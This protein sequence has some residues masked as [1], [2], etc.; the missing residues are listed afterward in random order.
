[1]FNSLLPW[2]WKLWLAQHWGWYRYDGIW[3]MAP[4]S[5]PKGQVLY[6]DGLWSAPMSL[7][8]A[9]DYARMFG[10]TVHPAGKSK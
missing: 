3:S 10:G 8:S 1:M 7:G 6:K 5:Y 2:S 9:V 4:D